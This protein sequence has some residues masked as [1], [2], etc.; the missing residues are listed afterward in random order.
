MP[1]QSSYPQLFEFLKQKEKLQDSFTLEETAMFCKVTKNTISKYFSEKLYN[2]ILTND[3][4]VY[5]VKSI[6]NMT[7]QDFEQII[8]Q[9]NPNKKLTNIEIYYKRLL[10]KSLDVFLIAIENYN[11]PNL[12][13]KVEVFSIL[14]VNAWELFLKARIIKEANKKEAIYKPLKNNEDY[15]ISIAECINILYKDES[16][17]KDNLLCLVELRDKATHLLVEE[18]RYSLSQ[19]FQ[20]SIINYIEAYNNNFGKIPLLEETTGMLCL[21]IPGNNK[22]NEI[23]AIYGEKTDIEINNFLN[24]LKKLSDTYNSDNF[25]TNINY[26][27]YI[28]KNINKS[29]ITLQNGPGG[30]N[31]V[32]INKEIDRNETHPYKFKNI[33][34]K[35]KNLHPKFNQHIM[36][37][38]IKK[39]KILEK[40]EY[41]YEHKNFQNT[42]TYSEKLVNL[43]KE[44]I[45]KD[46][47]F[48]ENIHI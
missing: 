48:F 21:I 22:I 43:I 3:K 36:H 37:K 10:D 7:Y 44:E 27:V 34:D 18:I 30:Q 42:K 20:A 24:K 5:K 15:T 46:S 12:K 6:L 33:V 2:Y 11:K 47:N 8:S 45:S 38:F 25:M 28:A 35:I 41:Y 17:I 40:S 39:Y 13:N 26:N 14:I 31:A 9:G 16:S 29:H 23:K 32:V 4:T 19:L 1:K